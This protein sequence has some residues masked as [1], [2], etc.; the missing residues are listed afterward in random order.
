MTAFRMNDTLEASFSKWKGLLETVKIHRMKLLE[1]NALRNDELPL[2]D[3][4]IEEIYLLQLMDK[5]IANLEH[6]II[7]GEIRKRSFNSI[8]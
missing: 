3:Q 2:S 7:H 4:Q 6:C 1:P 5:L 8:E